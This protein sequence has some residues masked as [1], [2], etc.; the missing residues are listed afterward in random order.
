MSEKSERSERK[1]IEKL[2]RLKEMGA[3]REQ[4]SP[5]LLKEAK[6]LGIEFPSCGE[7]IDFAEISKRTGIPYKIVYSIFTR[8]DPL[9]VKKKREYL[10]AVRKIKEYVEKEK[11][12]CVIPYL[13]NFERFLL[14]EV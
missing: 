4:L 11:L 1:T 10:D 12:K 6:K 8:V 14:K 7:L 9:R 3:V 13:E 5:S 2:N